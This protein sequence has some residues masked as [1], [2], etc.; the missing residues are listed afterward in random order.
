MATRSSRSTRR[1]ASE[2]PP[3]DRDLPLL[4]FRKYP[5]AGAEALDK[6]TL[7]VRIKGKY[8]QF[9]YWLAMTFF[10][11]IPWEA[12]KFYAPARHGRRRT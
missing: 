6:H 3:T 10:S 9:K 1:C 8:P 7:R 12:E 2:L 5:F 4:D 11:P